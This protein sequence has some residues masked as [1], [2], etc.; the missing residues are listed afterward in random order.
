MWNTPRAQTVDSLVLAVFFLHFP[1]CRANHVV[2]PGIEW[3][4]RHRSTVGWNG[5]S[6]SGSS[7]IGARLTEGMPVPPPSVEL[8]LNSPMCPSRA[9]IIAQLLL[10]SGTGVTV[11]V[12]NERL[13]W[14]EVL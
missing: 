2:S 14:H 7:R 11:A 8:K 6:E 1:D 3:Q 4:A 5:T 12:V 13:A 9:I 10:N